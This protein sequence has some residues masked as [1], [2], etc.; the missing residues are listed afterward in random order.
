[1]NQ[2]EVNMT[3]AQLLETFFTRLS[4]ILAVNTGPLG[5]QPV[6]ASRQSRLLQGLT[7]FFLV[8]IDYYVNCGLSRFNNRLTL[9]SVDMVK[10]NIDSLVDLT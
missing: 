5:G 8:V 2:V 1:M 9:G 7:D 4:S 10:S 3:N 6:L